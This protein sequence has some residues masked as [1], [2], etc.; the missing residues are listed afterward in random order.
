MRRR[1]PPYPR[2]RTLSQ[3]PPLTAP[4]SAPISATGRPPRQCPS[5]PCMNARAKHRGCAT[6]TRTIP[7]TRRHGRAR[8]E[9]PATTTGRMTC[10]AP[11]PATSSTLVATC[12]DS[13]MGKT[14]AS[15]SVS[16]AYTAVHPAAPTMA[17]LAR[18]APLTVIRAASMA[19]GTAVPT[20]F[21][22]PMSIPG[23]S[24][25]RKPTR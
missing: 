22:V 5:I 12:C 7:A 17:P 2:Y 11:I 3:P 15:A 21:P 24:W 18:V 10:T 9:P 19:H 14:A 8:W 25:A 20:S 16:W 23:C 1:T 6:P 4:K 13:P